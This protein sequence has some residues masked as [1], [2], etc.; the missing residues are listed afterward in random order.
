VRCAGHVGERGAASS[1]R[2]LGRRQVAGAR[3]HSC[4]LTDDGSFRWRSSC[5]RAAP[6]KAPAS[7]SQTWVNRPSTPSTVPSTVNGGGQRRI[8]VGTREPL[9]R[10]GPAI[11]AI[12]LQSRPKVFGAPLRWVAPTRVDLDHPFGAFT[13]ATNAFGLVDNHFA[14][15]IRPGSHCQRNQVESRSRPPEKL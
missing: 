12:C 13:P 7:V 6:K 1:G 4:C 10:A 8:D 9:M 3:S 2:S 11:A 14:S 15:R 5:G